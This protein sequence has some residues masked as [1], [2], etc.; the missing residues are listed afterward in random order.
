MAHSRTFGEC[1]EYT[2]KTRDSWVRERKAVDEWKRIQQLPK[3]ER[4]SG[5]SKPSMFRTIQ[6]NHV[7][8]MRGASYPV[9]R[10]DQAAVTQLIFELEDERNWTS[11]ETCN[12]VI[13]TI[14]TIVNHCK[15]HRFIDEVPFEA[16]EMF[17][18]SES[19]LTWFTMSQMEQLYEASCNVF[20]Y[21]ALGEIFL[22]LG[23][24]GMRL[25][26]LQKLRVMDIDIPNLRIHV[27]GRDGFVTKAKN[28][29]VIPIQD[30]ILP[31]M[32]ERTRDQPPR[33]HIFADDFGS[34]DSLRRSFNKIRN[35]VGIDEKHVIHSLRHSYA[36]FLNESGVPPMTIKDLMGHK[37]IETTLRYCK[38]SDVARNQ[39]H[40]ALN[41]QLQRA[42]QPVPEPAQPAQPSYDQLLN[43]VNAL[44]QLLAQMPQLAAMTRI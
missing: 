2:F 24:T 28:W 38:V 8:E 26:E 4:P 43:Q 5:I 12:K 23:L 27:G 9:S 35:Y 1:A 44:Q 36:T 37:R 16:L 6:V 11:K 31:F 30:R 29:R 3:D 15:R 10:L 13:D 34:A 20:G 19:R 42:T 14:R 33:K 18:G 21:P 17:S 25:G 40:Q 22:T 39:A 32:I 41:A 7:I